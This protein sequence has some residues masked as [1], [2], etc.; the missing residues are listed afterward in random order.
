MSSNAFGGGSWSLGVNGGIRA[1]ARARRD[2]AAGR[3]NR[4]RLRCRAPPNYRLLWMGGAISSLSPGR[5]SSSRATRSSWGGRGRG[6]RNESRC[7]GLPRRSGPGA[8]RAGSRFRPRYPES[9]RRRSRSGIDSP[10]GPRSSPTVMSSW[11]AGGVIGWSSSN[12]GTTAGRSS[13]ARPPG[14]PPTLP[15]RGGR[16]VQRGARFRPEPFPARL[17][18]G[19]LVGA[20][21][22]EAVTRLP[23]PLPVCRDV[24]AVLLRRAAPG[25]RPA[26]PRTAQAQRIRSGP[27]TSPPPGGPPAYGLVRLG[28]VPWRGPARRPASS[29]R[30][31][32]TPERRPDGRCTRVSSAPQFSAR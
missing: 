9:S 14:P 10:P 24:Y 22:R 32:P 23:P 5:S 4:G 13:G 16:L 1:Y 28:R 30:T 3:R 29:S 15:V 8:R 18:L 27:R 11:P 25:T 17:L 6:L 31:S 2:G 20:P 19:R 7:A 26:P 12:S 21:H